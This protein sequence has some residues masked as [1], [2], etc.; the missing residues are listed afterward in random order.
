MTEDK[1]RWLPVV[2][3]VWTG[4]ALTS[5]AATASSYA[6][7]WYVTESTGSPLSLALVYA[8]AFLPFGLLA[9]LGGVVADRF[10][11]KTIIIICDSFI[12][13]TALVM[14]LFIELGH[15]SLPIVLVMVT[16]F[17]I[18]QAFR[19]PAFN[20]AMPLLVPEEHL[21][22]INM[23]DN[24]LSSISMILAPALGIFLY[25]VIGFQACMLVD[26]VGAIAA[27][28]TM[29]VAHIPT[30]ASQETLESSAWSNLK[31]GWSA[32]YSNKGVLILV[33]GVTVGMMAYGPIDSL[34]P[35]MVASHFSG[36]GYMASLVT[37]VFGIGMLAGSLAIMAFGAGKRLVR[38]ITGAAL[39]V[40]VVTTIA[41]LLPSDLFFVYVITMGVMAF[42]CSGFNGPL[43]T[44]LQKSV[45]ETRLGRV[46]GLFSALIGL[47][48]PA[49]TALGGALA[50][51]IGVTSFFVVDGV[52]ILVLGLSLRLS[53]QVRSLDALRG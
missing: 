11:R 34:L 30:V 1:R 12:A 10:N 29:L 14:A 31:E 5:F 44:I 52:L 19:Q 38:I 46:M 25:T 21:M 32:L 48:I 9:P 50:E 37:A 26:A 17:G 47:G 45:D 28:L 42:A 41:G 22:R 36:D 51:S 2:A 27:V 3:T 24:I 40:G 39:A 33:L 53:R 13:I 8:F 49:G 23:L 7:V 18:G 16:L 20:S 6:A 4:F 35:L 43:M 15:M